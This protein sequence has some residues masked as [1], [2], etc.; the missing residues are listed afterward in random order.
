MS[1]GPCVKC[2][3]YRPVRPMSQLLARAFPTSA[4]DVAEALGKVVEDEQ[5][6]RD[7]EAEYKRSQASAGK[8]TWAARPVLSDYCGLREAEDRFYIAEVK[9][10]ALQCDD[11]DDAIVPS[12]ACETC[13]HEVPPEGPASDERREQMYVRLAAQNIS[14]DVKQDTTETLLSSYRQ[15]KAAR[16]ALEI[17]GSYQAKGS[18]LSPPAYLGYCDHFSTPNSYVL[19]L[20]KNPYDACPAWQTRPERGDQHMST[21]PPDDVLPPVFGQRPSSSPEVATAAV[22]QTPRIESAMF[23]RIL[24]MLGWLLNISVDQP[25]RQVLRGASTRWSSEDIEALMELVAIADNAHGQ[26]PDGSDFVRETYQAGF[27]GQLRTN[28]DPWA[29]ALVNAYDAANPA[30]A[31]GTPPLTQ[32]VVDSYLGI[33]SF[34]DAIIDNR[35]WAPMG[36]AARA[37]FTRQMATAYPA[38]SPPEQAWLAAIPLEWARTRALWI[39]ASEDQRRDLAQQ[40]VSLYGQTA[41]ATEVLDM[42]DAPVP[43]PV[44]GA[45]PTTTRAPTTRSADLSPSEASGLSEREL[46]AQIIADQKQEEEELLKTDRELALQVKLQ[47]QLK[48]ASLMSNMMSLRHQSAM[49]IIQNIR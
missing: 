38:L 3:W 25:L 27:V 44:F 17:S 34:V 21:S 9:N 45:T 6:Q 2:H 49:A 46:L 1:H 29:V 35:A 47:N 33:L 31:D 23:E 16:Q 40:L 42:A 32:E 20:F 10:A 41:Q 48:T 37:E 15:G 30:I 14:A 7:A 18:L 5:K 39:E 19:C 12:R 4:R 26:G 43:P 24:G 8:D 36:T 11:F 28:S 22:G 13:R